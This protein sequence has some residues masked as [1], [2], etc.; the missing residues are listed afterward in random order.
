MIKIKLERKNYWNE[1]GELFVAII[2]NTTCSCGKSTFS[3][4]SYTG[5]I[6]CPSCGKELLEI[7]KP[8]GFEYPQAQS[9]FYIERKKGKKNEKV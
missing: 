6:H 5:I 2:L 9:K 8:E 3:G 1:K 7:E 4:H